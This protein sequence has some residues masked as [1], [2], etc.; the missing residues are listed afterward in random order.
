MS[1]TYTNNVGR[2]D[3]RLPTVSANDNGKILQV[4]EGEWKKAEGGG[5]SSLPEYG[6]SDAGKVLSVAPD[7]ESVEWSTPSGGTVVN[8]TWS[9][10]TEGEQ[11]SAILSVPANITLPCIIS[12][13]PASLPDGWVLDDSAAPGDQLLTFGGDYVPFFHVPNALS[14]AHVMMGNINGFMFS[15]VGQVLSYYIPI[16]ND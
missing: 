1:E 9:Y 7:G 5:G 8:A 4:V 3:Y 6:E 12:I 2:S 15:A 13:P 14:I 10:D 11:P 16:A